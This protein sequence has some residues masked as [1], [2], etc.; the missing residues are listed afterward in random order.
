M[1]AMEVHLQQG[2]GAS[3]SLGDTLTRLSKNAPIE[4]W[5]RNTGNLKHAWHAWDIFWDPVSL[6]ADFQRA[7]RVVEKWKAGIEALPPLTF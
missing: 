5:R 6:A 7:A 4:S 2:G 3:K 1:Q